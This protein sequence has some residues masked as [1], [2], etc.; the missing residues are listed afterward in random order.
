MPANPTRRRRVNT[1]PRTAA[2]AATTIRTPVS[3]AALSFWPNVRIAKCLSHSGEASTA[4]PPTAMTGD[5]SGLVNP[6]S[7]SATPSAT[8]AASNPAAAPASRADG[9]LTISALM[10]VLRRRAPDGLVPTP[11]GMLALAGPGAYRRSEP[12]RP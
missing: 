8:P 7:S 5:A 1:T 11:R 3:S 10:P 6:A 2:S 12:V 9:V 4:A